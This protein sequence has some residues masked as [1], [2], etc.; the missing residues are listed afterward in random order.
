MDSLTD[1]VV[2]A[3]AGR[4]HSLVTTQVARAVLAFGQL[5]SDGDGDESL[6][7]WPTAVMV[8]PRDY[9]FESSRSL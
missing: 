7:L 9:L 1:A 6:L 2:G 5:G 3:A 4:Q 8:V